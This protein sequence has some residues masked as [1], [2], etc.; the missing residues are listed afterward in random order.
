MRKHAVYAL[1]TIVEILWSAV[2]ISLLDHFRTD[3]LVFFEIILIW[4]TSSVMLVRLAKKFVADP[5]VF[6]Q[7]QSKVESWN[8]LRHAMREEEKIRRSYRP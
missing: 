1:L 8:R 5:P 4:L 3:P 7:F 2:C 6:G